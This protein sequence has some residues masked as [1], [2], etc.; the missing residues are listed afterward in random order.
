MSL[1][2][3]Q[4][5]LNVGI[6]AVPLD[7]EDSPLE[8]RWI[9][10]ARQIFEDSTEY[11]DANIRY[12]W[13]KNLSLFNSNHPPGSKYNSSA[14]EKRSRFFR[15]KTRT[16]VRNLQAAMS[17]AFFTNEDVVSIDAANPNDEMNAAAAI[18]TQAVM[19]YRLTNT[20][21]WFQTMTAALQDAAV[22]GVC[23][24]HQ[25]WDFKENRESY[26]E[27]DN[28]NNPIMDESGEPQI[29]EQI[30]A[31]KD[32]ELARD[33]SGEKFRNYAA[34]LSYMSSQIL[35][36]ESLNFSDNKN[37]SVR[38]IV[39]ALIST[40]VAAGIAGSSRPCSGSEHLISHALDIVSPNNGLHGEKCGMASIAMSKL[41]GLD[42]QEIRNALL[43]VNCPTNVNDLG[44]TA[45]E[46]IEAINLAPTIRPER[47]T[48]LNTANLERESIRKLLS[49]TN[50]I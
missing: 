19:Q 13:E 31:I 33:N 14:Y 30:T 20:I 2:N 22:Q 17:V 40:G 42:W 24:S 7:Q 35:F 1:I 46:M 23:V 49:D 21:P 10:L 44:I 29:H 28:A 39:E 5:P 47:Y 18:V 48:I 45:D 50:C 43:R 41:H 16:A 8:N 36:D 27:V 4:P 12:Q 6:D 25:Y 26:V 15:P 32:W 11:L 9:R 3:P 34:S 37:D 38:D